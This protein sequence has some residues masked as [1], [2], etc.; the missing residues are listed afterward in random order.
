VNKKNQELT[1]E[2][3]SL[4]QRMSKNEA[5]HQ[6]QPDKSQSSAD[7]GLTTEVDSLRQQLQQEISKSE[8]LRQQMLEHQESQK[9]L[10]QA[11]IRLQE[12]TLKIQELTR[13]CKIFQDGMYELD[14]Q[15]EQIN[16]E[17]SCAICLMPW[18]AEGDHRL[19]SLHC[20]HL[21]GE[22]CILQHLGN[23]S[24]CPLCKQNVQLGD[25]RYL[26]GSRV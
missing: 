12:M 23:R 11:T 20:G 26:F 9:T 10:Q 15:L 1:A 19:I 13:Q 17:N 25:L 22:H 24:K 14:Q 6:P 18:K 5:Q 3:D 21:F 8:A 4:L 7:E 2:R 16:D